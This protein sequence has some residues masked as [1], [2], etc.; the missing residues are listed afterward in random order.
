MKI[1]DIVGRKSY[2]S[3][4]LF[5]V[6]EIFED[7]KYCLTGVNFR[8]KIYTT[9]DDLEPAAIERV[10][11]LRKEFLV[12]ANKK[13]N[14]ILSKRVFNDKHYRPGKVLHIDSDPEYLTIC[15]GYYKKLAIPAVGIKIREKEQPKIITQLLQDHL[16]DILIITGHDSLTNSCNPGCVSNYRSSEHFIET[17]KAARRTNP[18]KDS[19]V[20]IAG[21]CQS[22]FEGIIM[23]E[24]NIAASPARIL[25]H[26]L[27][28]VFAAER[29]AYTGIDKVLSIEEILENNITGTMGMGGYETRG[30]LRKGF[31]TSTF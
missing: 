3:D 14:K 13:I 26:A 28:P 2:G 12:E 24:A 11:E 4:I 27:D 6:S 10:L 31:G 22:Y 29:I 7:G 17:V 30:V 9:L 5:K 16:P 8:L 25:I 18:S 20:I 1:G 15:L 23:A 19:L 21:A